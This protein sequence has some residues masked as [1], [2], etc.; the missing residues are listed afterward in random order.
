MTTALPIPGVQSSVVADWLTDK[1]KLI[2]LRLSEYLIWKNNAEQAN[3]KNT[4]D[5]VNNNRAD[6]I[7]AL[8]ESYRLPELDTLAHFV[9]LPGMSKR[10]LT[11]FRSIQWTSYLDGA[12]RFETLARG[13][14]S[15]SQRV[16]VGRFGEQCGREVST[17]RRF[18]VS[19]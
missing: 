16:D 5:N 3:I 9:Q 11:V 8:I 15:F 14:L 7:P 4:A 12:G 17:N 13:K 18:M 2:V 19:Y 10:F 6:S 1:W